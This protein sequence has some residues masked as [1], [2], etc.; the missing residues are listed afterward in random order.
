MLA[1]AGVSSCELASG[2]LGAPAA[3]TR[4]WWVSMVRRRSTVR[5]RKGAPRS[6]MFFASITDD[7]LAEIPPD[8]PPPRRANGERFQPGIRNRTVL[9]PLQGSMMM[10][11][12]P[13]HR[14]VIGAA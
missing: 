8:C 7:L 14:A 10:G 1:V 13:A 6:R 12:M 2:Q 9:P 4:T 11:V 5:F 3:V